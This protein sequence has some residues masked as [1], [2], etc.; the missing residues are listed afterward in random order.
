[1]K[2]RK[3]VKVVLVGTDSLH[4][5]EMKNVLSKK[6]FPLGKIDFFDP[7]VESEYSKLTQFRGEA[8]VIYPLDKNSISMADLVFL[9]ANKSIS[10]EY[11]I[12]ASKAK[13]R[14]IDLCGA[15]NDEEKIPIVV[16]GV[17]DDIILSEKFGLIANPHPVTIILSHLFHP[18][19]KK[20]GLVKAIAFVLQPVSAFGDN[21]IKELAS[22]SV[23]V[24]SSSSFSKKVFK[25]QIAFNLLSHTEAIDKNGVSS[26]ERQ[27]ISEIRRVLESSSFP[28]S[29]SVVQAPVFHAY[30]I[31]TY[32]ELEKK[33]SIL[34]LENLFKK[35][36][37]FK[38]SPLSLSSPVSSVL[39]VGKDK[40]FIG[41]IKKEE[42][43]PNGFWVWAVA[44][45]LTCGSAL[46]AF[47][48]A[49]KSFF[50]SSA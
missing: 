9:A 35:S 28:I 43:F 21:G 8:K 3:R 38:L 27:I 26:I 40:I 30:S 2:G 20:F 41:P 39:V 6:K 7:D 29:L 19:V 31:M 46:N 18:A 13:F 45:N 36:P 23:A 44:D 47:E 49:E 34:A 1:M 22:Q 10:R 24:L 12:L 17:N 33:A 50:A 4:G 25:A 16:A 14:A 37:Y 11:G 48:I 15:F 5:K 32:L 42:S